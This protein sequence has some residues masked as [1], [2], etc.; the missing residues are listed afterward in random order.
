MDQWLQDKIKR[1]FVADFKKVRTAKD[2]LKVE[3]VYGQYLPKGF[4]ETVWEKMT[5]KA[6]Q[7]KAATAS[8]NIRMFEAAERRRLKKAAVKKKKVA[9]KK[10][11]KKAAKKRSKKVVH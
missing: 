8:K 1:D 5:K 3:K 9:K 11:T 4:L 6:K 7:K 2:L 10:A